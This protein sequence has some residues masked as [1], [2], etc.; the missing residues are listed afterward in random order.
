ML[1]AVKG[2]QKELLT[3]RTYTQQSRATLAA[4]L[5]VAPESVERWEKSTAE[6]VRLQNTFVDK[7]CATYRKA[8]GREAKIERGGASVPV[9]TRRGRKEAKQKKKR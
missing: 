4:D 1:I 5:G 6:H 7:F 3:Y 9:L 2:L 8:L